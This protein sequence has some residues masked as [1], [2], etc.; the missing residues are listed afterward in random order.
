M[1][2]KDRIV[3]INVEDGNYIL[4]KLKDYLIVYEDDDTEL[5][6]PVGYYDETDE[7]I[8]FVA[9]DL[10][11]DDYADLY[12]KHEEIRKI[13]SAAVSSYIAELQMDGILQVSV[14]EDLDDV[15]DQEPV[16]PPQVSMTDTLPKP[17]HPMNDPVLSE[18]LD[19]SDLVSTD[20]KI[21]ELIDDESGSSGAIDDIDLDDLADLA[22]AKLTSLDVTKLGNIDIQKTETG[23]ILIKKSKQ[24]Y[25]V[26]YPNDI[27]FAELVEQ[28]T[29]QQMPI[30]T[31]QSLVDEYLNMTELGVDQIKSSHDSFQK[32]KYINPMIYDYLRNFNENESELPKYS[33]YWLIPIVQ[34]VKKV[35][36]SQITDQVGAKLSTSFGDGLGLLDEIKREN[37]ILSRIHIKTDY[38]VNSAY[39]KSV[40]PYQA[41]SDSKDLIENITSFKNPD[42]DRQDYTIHVLRYS[43]IGTDHL[44]LRKAYGPVYKVNNLYHDNV[45]KLTRPITGIEH[46]LSV[47]GERVNVVGFMRLPVR[48]AKRSQNYNLQTI[49]AEIYQQK[50]QLKVYRNIAEIPKISTSNINDVIAVIFPN[51]SGL[52]KVED[53]FNSVI[54]NIQT[55]FQIYDSRLN[56]INNLDRLNKLLSY[57]NLNTKVLDEVSY[58][59]VVQKLRQQ[60]QSK[61]NSFTNRKD[62]LN[63]I[64]ADMKD[65]NTKHMK[66]IK[67]ISDKILNHKMIVQNYGNYPDFGKLRDS[68]M[69]RLAWIQNQL[70][71]G[72]LFYSILNYLEINTYFLK[73]IKSRG[74]ITLEKLKEANFSDYVSELNGKITT[75]RAELKDAENKLESF[76]VSHKSLF[77]QASNL[78]KASYKPL[79]Y[80]TN[81]DNQSDL[82]QA[83]PDLSNVFILNEGKYIPQNVYALSEQINGLKWRLISYNLNLER[84]NNITDITNQAHENIQQNLTRYKLL[85]VLLIRSGQRQIKTDIKMS[86]L[87]L[88]DQT[89]VDLLGQIKNVNAVKAKMLYLKLIENYGMVSPD[90]KWIISKSSLKRICC[91]HKKEQ[92]LEHSLT[93]F[94]DTK[95]PGYCII[96]AEQIGEID[97]D[98]F[99]GYDADDNP[100]VTHEGNVLDTHLADLALE[101]ANQLA[102]V[103]PVG[104][105]CDKQ[106]ADNENKRYACTVLKYLRD[107]KQLGMNND[108]IV[109]AVD[110]FNS[111]IKL[112]D[113]HTNI[114]INPANKYLQLKVIEQY[115]NYYQGKPKKPNP[116]II[117]TLSV[118][119]IAISRTFD[120]YALSLVSGIINLELSQ[121]SKYLSDTATKLI[122]QVTAQQM[123]E[124]KGKSRLYGLNMNQINFDGQSLINSDLL[125][126]ITSDPKLPYIGNLSDVRPSEYFNRKMNEFYNFLIEN[127]DLANRYSKAMELVKDNEIKASAESVDPESLLTVVPGITSF[128]YVNDTGYKQLIKHITER[129]N[130]LSQLSSIKS[131]KLSKYVYNLIDQSSNIMTKIKGY[132]INQDCPVD[133][134]QLYANYLMNSTE[135]KVSE[136]K[137]PTL[138]KKIGDATFTVNLAVNNLHPSLRVKPYQMSDQKEDFSQLVDLTEDTE[139]NTMK[140][141]IRMIN[142]ELKKLNYQFER[143]QEKQRLSAFR[144][145]FLKTSIDNYSLTAPENKLYDPS[146]V[147]GW[148]TL[149]SVPIPLEDSKASSFSPLLAASS[150]TGANIN[151]L[152]SAMTSHLKQ[153]PN[154][155]AKKYLD[156]LNNMGDQK[157]KMEEIASKIDEIKNKANH[158]WSGK[159]ISN[160]YKSEVFYQQVTLKRD[161]LKSYLYL[162]HYVI[163]VIRN[164]FNIA[165]Y[166]D[167][168]EDLADFI[169][170]FKTE[171]K[172][173]HIFSNYKYLLNIEQLSELV[174]IFQKE[175]ESKEDSKALLPGDVNKILHYVFVTE[176]VNGFKNIYDLTDYAT[177]AI[178]TQRG[179]R[180]CQFVTR[181]LDIIDGLNKINN[182]TSIEI[183]N[184]F[185][186]YISKKSASYQALKNKMDKDA[187]AIFNNQMKY[188][189]KTMDSLDDPDSQ[190]IYKPANN[191]AKL[192][193]EEKLTDQLNVAEDI[194]ANDIMGEVEPE[195]DNPDTFG[196]DVGY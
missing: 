156:I 74:S 48:V 11:D 68:D 66:S 167:I 90:E 58:N 26:I 165:V 6:Q 141:G 183:N 108:Q 43:T 60:V 98:V 128:E 130:Y 134:R 191:G 30:S 3:V 193:K 75:T 117:K 4:D 192:T 73:L 163:S 160:L 36:S 185:M 70:D 93:K 80:V 20:G 64:F 14:P 149:K 118:S 145:D 137:T 148:R 190:D 187:L 7:S 63:K 116:V 84:I 120:N 122:N 151:Y 126:I 123:T 54:P 139:L 71:N 140:D 9:P 13:D 103:A 8:N 142:A 72:R 100:I 143:L 40:F 152:V 69:N 146:K 34:D 87:S 17:S 178:N 101:M 194:T 115:N 10:E 102:D 91:A 2:V 107:T 67:F 150:N 42:L 188:K 46:T 29:S 27:L 96:C 37:D 61:V 121:P 28:L 174:G 154:Y 62:Q 25:E 113:L 99:G 155:N 49:L 56:K 181:L 179:I 45:K 173:S 12:E 106:F 83:L 153:I 44:E 104:F 169:T 182:T 41:V 22:E 18:Q 132:P 85:K 147:K 171:D 109:N 175:N 32:Y 16:G 125:K 53:M 15:V 89:I 97:F 189:F 129:L 135:S 144:G 131:Q 195:N 39:V 59:K 76:R 65:S 47:E 51:G 57:Y 164:D 172:E 33:K 159:I 157:Q 127:G 82:N 133:V 166:A 21:G 55:I 112:P 186:A 176:L 1:D 110:L 79:I 78:N 81:I 111:V 88:P 5:E 105:D 23:Q 184:M 24:E 119:S 180:Y 161:L 170:Y 38:D 77:D 35:Y 136:I 196:D 31:A 158:E 50:R 94:E 177:P 114:N 95:N 19:E 138:E 52:D 124:Q 92:L 162:A 86:D 168:N